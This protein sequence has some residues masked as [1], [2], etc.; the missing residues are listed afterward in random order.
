MVNGRFNLSSGAQD[1]GLERGDARVKL[2]DRK[3][4]E[5]LA[6][7]FRRQIAGGAG[8]TVV[9]FHNGQQR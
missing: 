5:I 7:E 4:V 8:Q 2:V 1:F 9:G 6:R 3:P